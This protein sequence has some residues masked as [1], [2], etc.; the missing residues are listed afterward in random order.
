[1]S[2]LTGLNAIFRKIPIFGSN[3]GFRHVLQE[4][5]KTEGD[6]SGDYTEKLDQQIVHG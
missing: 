1:M 6:R 4:M 5:L 3:K 2:K